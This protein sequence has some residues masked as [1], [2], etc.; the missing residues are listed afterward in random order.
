[1]NKNF[2][3][4]RGLLDFENKEKLQ[5]D[6]SLILQCFRVLQETPG[7]SGFPEQLGVL[8]LKANFALYQ[9]R[10]RKKRILNIFKREQK[11]IRLT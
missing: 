5:K 2:L 1:M 9:K 7:V 8:E 3:E 11:V 4:F 6:P 10:K